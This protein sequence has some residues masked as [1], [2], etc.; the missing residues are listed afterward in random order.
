MGRHCCGASNPDNRRLQMK[1]SKLNGHKLTVSCTSLIGIV[2][3]HWL[4]NYIIELRKVWA[5]INRP[6]KTGPLT[7]S[8]A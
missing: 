6:T 1:A 5:K 7:Y 8:F 4:I 2:D 3:S